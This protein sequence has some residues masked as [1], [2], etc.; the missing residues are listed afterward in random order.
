MA[1]GIVNKTFKVIGVILLLGLYTTMQYAPAYQSIIY[2]ATLVFVS[3]VVN[4]TD[5]FES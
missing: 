2:L 5:S 4:N 1:K 3:I